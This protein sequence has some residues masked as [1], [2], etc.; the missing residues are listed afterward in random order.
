MALI[1]PTQIWN[2]LF[3]GNHELLMLLSE[4]TEGYT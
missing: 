3:C 4:S 1:K 2:I